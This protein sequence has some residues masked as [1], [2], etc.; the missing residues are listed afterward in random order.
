MTQAQIEEKKG[1]E[2]T[3]VKQTGVMEPRLFNIVNN[4]DLNNYQTSKLRDAMSKGEIDGVV[5]D[6]KTGNFRLADPKKGQT[7]EIFF[8]NDEIARETALSSIDN[9]IGNIEKRGKLEMVASKTEEKIKTT[10]TDTKVFGSD[11]EKYL[12]E[13]SEDLSLNSELAIKYFVNLSVR[14]KN[15][16]NEAEGELSN[17]RKAALF[18]EAVRAVNRGMEDQLNEN[19]ETAKKLEDATKVMSSSIIRGEEKD[20]GDRLSSL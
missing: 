2:E 4:F 18:N 3:K 15:N 8:L 14:Y 13:L 17:Y 20:I 9:F 11:F 16:L 7:E 1:V 10:Q 19:K 5:V 6:E 12:G